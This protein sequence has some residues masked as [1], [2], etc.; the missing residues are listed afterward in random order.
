MRIP[1]QVSPPDL[2]R[3]S[4]LFKPCHLAERSQ[5]PAALGGKVDLHDVISLGA[6]SR[7]QPETH[8]ITVAVQIF[9]LRDHFSSHQA[10]H[11]QSHCPRFS[12]RSPAALRSKL[13]SHLGSLPFLAGIRVGCS[14]NFP[15]GF[16][17][18]CAEWLQ[19]LKVVAAQADLNRLGVPAALQ[20]GR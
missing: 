1:H 17:Q 12:P 9:E 2:G 16:H 14:G 18:A 3:C 8:V 19:S 11:R 15:N 7:V 5:Y 6:L 13:D 10:A 20:Q 4:P